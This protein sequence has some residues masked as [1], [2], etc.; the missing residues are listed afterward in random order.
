MDILHD[1]ARQSMDKD[2]FIKL[3]KLTYELNPEGKGKNRIRSL[4]DVIN[5]INNTK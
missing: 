3:V 5:E 4:E 1:N 2:L